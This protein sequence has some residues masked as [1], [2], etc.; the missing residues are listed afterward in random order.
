[1][2]QPNNQ[3]NPRANDPGA[4]ALAVLQGQ[5]NNLNA[6][7]AGMLTARGTIRQTRQDIIYAKFLKTP[8]AMH[9]ELNPSYPSLDC[10]GVRFQPWKKALDRTLMHA[11]SRVASFLDDP[12]LFDSL[13]IKES[14][15]VDSLIRNTLESDLLSLVSATTH[16]TVKA[17]YEFITSQCQHS[18][19]R[20]KI[21]LIDQV[22]DLMT[23]PNPSSEATLAKWSQIGADVKQLKMSADELLGI[24]LQNTFKP[25]AGTESLT[26]DFSVSQTLDA[27]KSPLLKEVVTVI[28]YATSKHRP[29][30]GADP[31]A[32]D[33]D[34]ISAFQGRGPQKY[35]SPQRRSTTPDLPK[36]NH[37]RFSVDRAHHF[38][39]KG[40]TPEQTA[41]HG[42]TCVYCSKNG[43]WY[44]DCLEFWRAVAMQEIEAPPQDYRLK[45]SSYIP[46][47]KSEHHVRKVDFPEA[48]DGVLLDS[49]ASAHDRHRPNSDTDGSDHDS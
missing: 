18:D 4:D 13:E 1:M 2:A 36:T 38:R 46:P 43:H 34:R 20:H 26:F 19:R 49:G 21:G 8:I 37:A 30:A 48:S 23:D 35:I 45:S 15:T 47:R 44:P 28:Q 42:T 24:F 31:H 40:Q 27:K 9:K 25:P 12:N 41:K 14:T 29:K 32:M 3:A 22:Y 16:K 11:F 10:D 39:G 17:L 7:I 5:I 6:Q 33:L